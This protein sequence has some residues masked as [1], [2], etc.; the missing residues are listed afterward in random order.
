MKLHGSEAFGPSISRW[1]KSFTV[2]LSCEALFS[3]FISYSLSFEAS[4]ESRTMVRHC[5]AFGCT[6]RSDKPACKGLSWHSLPL[7]NKELLKTWLVKIRR[8][9]TPLSK[10]SFLCSEHFD[11]ECFTRSFAGRKVSLKR[12]S[13]PTLF[14][15][16]SEKTKRN[17]PKERYNDVDLVKPKAA[18]TLDMSSVG[19]DVVVDENAFNE[20]LIEESADENMTNE[21]NDDVDVL[22]EEQKE[23]INLKEQLTKTEQDLQKQ[24]EELKLQ[25]EEEKK[26]RN[27][28][29]MLLKKHIFRI[30]NIKTNDK[31]LR[32][33]T[34]FANYEIFTMVLDILGRDAAANL[35]YQNKDRSKSDSTRNAGPGRTLSI[36]N[37]FL[38][39][40]CRLKTG[41][42]EEDLA[43]RFCVAQSIVSQ[44]VNTWIKF[45]YFR[46]KEL[47][48]FPSKDTV[49]VHRPEC[50]NK[51]YKSTTIIIDAT[52]IYIEKPSNPAAQQI[53]FSSYKNTNTLKALVGIIPKGVI[54]FVSELYGGSISDKDLTQKSGLIDKLQR[55][56][57]V[58]ADRG[59]NIGGDLAHKGVPVNL[60]PFMDPSGQFDEA[61]MLKTRRIASL[62]IHVERAIERIKNYH[63]LD[64]IPISMCKNGIIDMIFFVCCML[65]NFLPPLV[66]G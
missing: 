1:P 49:D 61:D 48:I 17:P 26:A 35:N 8:E 51:Q 30:E 41:L 12:G 25:L 37:E 22:S 56:D 5:V 3:T 16:T 4:E 62:R 53:T 55:G 28:M 2:I 43:T 44:I 36:E 57:A 32:F 13:V 27:E 40:L 42:L 45:M 60:P 47:D 7:N 46:F 31:L 11:K 18:K 19:D 58:M 63:I 9:N 64:F 14:C 39:V 6:N 50:F 34:G 21:A 66:D 52:E 29:E 59:F 54:S 24:I 20:Q 23:I 10:N 33:Y 38:M 65:T 15:F